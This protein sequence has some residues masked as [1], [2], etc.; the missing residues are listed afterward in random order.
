ML[1]ELDRS[2]LNVIV[3]N[4]PPM[5]EREREREKERARER[6]RERER[7]SAVA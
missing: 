7:E 2:G 4:L 1:L 3:V 6:E 5:R